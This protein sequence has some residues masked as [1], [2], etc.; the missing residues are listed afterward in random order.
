MATEVHPPLL[1]TKLAVPPVRP[2][3]VSRRRLTKQ[4]GRALDRKLTLISAPAGFGKTTLV[5]DWLS[6]AGFRSDDGLLP[7]SASTQRRAVWLS[8]DPDDNDPARFLAYLTAALQTVE[9]EWGQMAHEFLRSPQPPPA[10]RLLTLLINEVASAPWRLVLVLDDYHVITARP[11]HDVLGHLLDHMPPNLHLIVLTRADPPLSLARRRAQGELIEIRQADLC[12]SAEET[13]AWLNDIMGLGLIPE[14][15]SALCD[16]TEGWI[17]GLVL[18]ALSLQRLSDAEGVA[19]FLKAF[20]GSHRYVMD[21]LVEEVVSQQPR[22]VQ[23]FLL[24][25]SIL[26]RMSGPLCD[27]VT[28][29]S[30]SQGV[31]EGLDQANLFVIPLDDQRRWYRYHPLFADLLRDRLHHLQPELVP[32]L[33][34]RAS[35]W[36]ECHGFVVAAVSHAVST[37]DPRYAAALIER[38]VWTLLDRGEMVLITSWLRHLPEKEIRARPFLCLARAWAELYD[39]SQSMRSAAEVA[40]QWVTAAEGAA[41]DLGDSAPDRGRFASHVAALCARLAWRRG[42]APEDVLKAGR[43]ALRTIPQDDL[44]LRSIVLYVLGST[45]G[46]L[47]H[48]RAAIEALAEAQE[49]AE[50]SGNLRIA[51]LAASIRGYFAYLQGHLHEAAATCRHVLSKYVEPDEESGRAL[52]MAGAVYVVLGGV[53]L[54]WNEL[55]EAERILSRGMKLLERVGHVDPFIS[56][57]GYEAQVRLRKRCGDIAGAQALIGQIQGMVPAEDSFA[58][59]Q[60]VRLW[61]WQAGQDRHAL[62]AA[63]QWVKDHHL[64]LDFSGR[65]SR[66]QLAL[67][68]LLIAQRRASPSGSSPGATQERADLDRILRSLEGQFQA[69]SEMRRVPWMLETGLLQGLAR[70]A[71]NDGEGALMALSKALDLARTEGHMGIFLD[72]GEPMRQLLISAAAQGIMPEYAARLLAAFRDMPGLRLVQPLSLPASGL[73]EPLTQRELEVLRLISAGLRN[74]EIADHLVISLA[75]VKRHISNLYGKLGVTHRTQAVARAREMDLLQS[76]D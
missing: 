10:T 15:V 8:L 75:T 57:W 28:G 68:R 60:Q 5:C 48:E 1:T 36:C 61:L 53:L 47:A 7:D 16:R 54:E 67:A 72:E 38:Q 27:A 69:A 55:G 4:L 51:L 17:A 50:A 23:S 24:Q 49:A 66:T 76:T 74:Q 19:S 43:R 6:E 70:Q 40:D 33:H 59:V 14:Q 35:E 12:F 73:A 46:G 42:D 65:H 9:P 29:R 63:A 11:V 21:Y 22:E 39:P 32:V 2:R 3:L 37:S 31:I 41:A 71:W 34:R 18:A 20:A 30:G 26:D 25:T 13:A 64:A 44:H 58:A 52:P 56:Q 62:N 45:H